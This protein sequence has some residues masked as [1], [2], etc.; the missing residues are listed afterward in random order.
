[1]KVRVLQIIPPSA[2]PPVVTTGG[3]TSPVLSEAI[4]SNY[5]TK[6]YE[7]TSWKENL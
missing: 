5:K 2:P 4:F 6:K 7:K 1:M 3:T